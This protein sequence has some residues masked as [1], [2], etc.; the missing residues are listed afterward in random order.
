MHS[1][2]GNGL[3]NPKELQ[4]FFLPLILATYLGRGYVVKQVISKLGKEDIFLHNPLTGKPDQFMLEN[5]VAEQAATTELK[6]DHSYV[7]WDGGLPCATGLR[8]TFID[9]QGF[10]PP[11]DE[12]YG[13]VRA[14]F[15][16]L[17]FDASRFEVDE[18]QITV[19]QLLDY[20]F[21][22]STRLMNI[23]FYDCYEALQNNLAKAPHHSVTKRR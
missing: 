21:A 9:F 10:M 20:Q 18:T 3:V 23:T 16:G 22:M 7:V 6:P 4:G 13:I 8:K 2:S 15:R 19:A 11:P 1:S 5:L 14:S 17:E 12:R